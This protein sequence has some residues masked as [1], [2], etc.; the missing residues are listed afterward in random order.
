MGRIMMEN[1][2]LPNPNCIYPIAGYKEEIYIKPTIQN[3][4]II[5]GD[6]PILQIPILKAT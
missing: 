5:V 2:T 1:S 6:S 3:P 4:N